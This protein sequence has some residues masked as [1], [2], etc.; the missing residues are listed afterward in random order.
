M[1]G[2]RLRA[3][4]KACGPPALAELR[5]D[6]RPAAAFSRLELRQVWHVRH[7][8]RIHARGHAHAR[9]HRRARRAAHAISH[10]VR[11]AGLPLTGAAARDR[12]QRQSRALV[13]VEAV[14]YRAEVGPQLG[15]VLP[16]DLRQ[17][18]ARFVLLGR[19]DGVQCVAAWTPLH[20]EI[21]IDLAGSHVLLVAH[22][23]PLRLAERLHRLR[24]PAAHHAHRVSHSVPLDELRHRRGG[25]RRGQ[26]ATG[27]LGWRWHSRRLLEC[28]PEILDA[29]LV[30]LLLPLVPLP[31]AQHADGIREAGRDPRVGREGL[32]D[33][34]LPLV[35]LAHLH[36]A[37]EDLD[38]ALLGE[39]VGVLGDRQDALRGDLRAVLVQQLEADVHLL[40]GVADLPSPKVLQGDLDLQAVALAAFVLVPLARD[41]VLGAVDRQALVT[42]LQQARLP[43]EQGLA[44]R[45]GGAQQRTGRVEPHH[46]HCRSLSPDSL[47][48]AR[49][50]RQPAGPDRLVMRI[51]RDGEA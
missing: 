19:H 12:L 20:G 1:L 16:Q 33:E 23:D 27:R 38:V 44:L 28:S 34:A 35:P 43:G 47:E 11:V 14:H 4:G 5:L 22:E 25:G 3:G 7:A 15:V 24:D 39:R 21:P 31:L 32:D 49:L 37:G 45:L 50:Q 29:L 8:E 2:V 26:G 17:L 9:Q 13:Q 48:K 46:Q 41:L 36:D 51:P 18:A 30:L 40:V 42:D 10:S 6:R